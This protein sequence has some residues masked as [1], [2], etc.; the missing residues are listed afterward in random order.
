M[1]SALIGMF[2]ATA[3]FAENGKIQ[4]VE[5]S[6]TPEPDHVNVRIVFPQRGACEREA[7]ADIEVKM[8][9]YSVGVTEFFE[10]AR[11]VRKIRE[12]QS[13]HVFIDNN[14]Y[15]AIYV[16]TIDSYNDDEHYFLSILNFNVPYHLEPGLH[17]VRVFP[18]RAFNESLKNPGCYDVS[19]FYYMEKKGTLQV[20]LN[21]PYLTF[22]EPQGKFGGNR[23]ILLDFY[24]SNC[25]LSCDGY[26]V[27][28]T[29]DGKDRRLLTKWAPY[30]IHGLGAGRHTLR[31][32]LID[33]ANQSVPGQY[34][35]VTRTILIE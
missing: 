15:F 33:K 3:L 21:Q 17:V 16:P 20:D 30:Y 18:V 13:L 22:N 6:R 25:D 31:L 23:P 11:E 4:V 34:N 14:P 27:R 19:Y 1:R 2:L 35:D 5:M 10:R 9:G 32:E 7:P 29:I 26:K 24:I 28:L 8:E 12:G